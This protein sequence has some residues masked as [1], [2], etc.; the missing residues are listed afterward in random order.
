MQADLNSYRQRQR[1]TWGSSI[2]LHRLS[3]HFQPASQRLIDW[4]E[5]GP[6][7]RVLDIATGTGRTA[8]LA[9][10]TGATV[11]A[12]DLSPVLIGEAEHFALASG[13]PDITLTESD[14]EELPYR[15]E[16]FS[17]VVSTFGA[18]HA[19]RPDVVSAEMNRVLAFGGRLGL[20]VWTYNAAI[21]R[22]ARLVPGADPQMRGAVDPSEWGRLERIREF[23][24]QRHFPTLEYEEGTLEISY[25]TVDAAWRDWSR[26]Y[27]P[28]HA[29]YQA[30]P[31]RNRD[32]IDQAAR[33]FFAQ[34]ADD[35]GAVTWPL[36]YLLISGIKISLSQRV[37]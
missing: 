6:D 4:L 9:R 23:I 7:D 15:A 8:V 2:G 37:G 36:D 3:G 32:A 17:V 12:Q 19:P 33:E 11:E 13:F 16:T 29:A 20:A 24:S 14:A 10:S 35:S 18:M 34:W 5:V 22:L 31:I 25:P 27:G 26:N 1:Q 28:I 21:Y 30:I